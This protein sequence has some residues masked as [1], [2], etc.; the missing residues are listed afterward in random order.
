MHPTF[1]SIAVVA[2]AAPVLLSAA[3]AV[4]TATLLCTPGWRGSAVGQYGGVGFG[5]SCNN[6]RGTD[7]ILDSVGTAWSLRMGV[8]GDTVDFTCAGVVRLTIR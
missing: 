5:V 6:G 8:E 1:R 7:R 4:K 3:P 2:I